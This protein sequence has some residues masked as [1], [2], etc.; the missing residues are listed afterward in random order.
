MKIKLDENMPLC[1]AA[2]LGVL[3]HDVQTVRE[4]GMEGHLDETIWEIAQKEYRFLITQ[5]LD[6]ADARRYAPGSHRGILLVRLR[7]PKRRALIRRVEELFR[8]EDV[9]R[10]ERCMVSA[11][12]S[13]VRV[14]R[15]NRL[16]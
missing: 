4:E 5:D 9:S 12:E 2:R 1:L 7:I 10:W 14:R 16:P 3:G 6:I 11:T 8:Q 15:P 13:K